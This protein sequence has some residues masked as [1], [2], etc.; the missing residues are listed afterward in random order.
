MHRTCKKCHFL[1]KDHREEDGTVRSLSLS[2]KDRE[3]L[4]ALDQ[5]Y[6]L[7]CWMKVWDEGLFP[8][9]VSRTATICE[10]SRGDS[11]FFWSHQPNML[12]AGAKELQMRDQEGR[13][14]RRSNFYTRIGLWIAAG[15]LFI[16]AIV[17]LTESC[18]K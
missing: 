17:R 1:T 16:D 2:E 6:S 11:C 7:N 3:G 5:R 15:A 10:T 12:F 13:Q 9:P 14:V 8:H 18:S 4:D